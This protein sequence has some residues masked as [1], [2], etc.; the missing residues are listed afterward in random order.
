MGFLPCHHDC[1]SK[2]AW[3]IEQISLEMPVL[4][5]YHWSVHPLEVF[6]KEECEMLPQTLMKIAANVTIVLHSCHSCCQVKFSLYCSEVFWEVQSDALRLIRVLGKSLKAPFHLCI[7]KSPQNDKNNEECDGVKYHT[8]LL[9]WCPKDTGL[10]Y[11]H[12]ANT[13]LT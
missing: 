1:S 8:H 6:V 11:M 12:K 9:L 3:K 2:V 13:H 10:A 4:Y 5:L 7:C